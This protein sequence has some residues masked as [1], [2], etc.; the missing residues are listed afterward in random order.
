MKDFLNRT[1]R[2]AVWLV[3]SGLVWTA[4]GAAPAMALTFFPVP[5]AVS[6]PEIANPY[7]GS[8]EWNNETIQPSGWPVTDAY[9]RL[10]WNQVESDWNPGTY[11]FGA[12]DAEL[13]QVHRD[14]GGRVG[15]RIMAAN[16]SDG[17]S[18]VPEYL[19]QQMPLGFWFTHPSEGTDV[20]APDW[21]DPDFLDRARAL[22]QAL[23]ARY[24]ADP[25]F[26]WLDIGFYGDWGEWH[27]SQWPYPSP[28][29]AVPMTSQNKHL[30]ID[31][32]LQ[33]FPGKPLVMIIDDADG[34]AYALGQ[35]GRVGLR[36]D[37][38][39]EYGFQRDMDRRFS[40]Y[41]PAAER[42]KTAPIITEF[43]NPPDMQVAYDQV[44]A[45]HVS[46]VGNGNFWELSHYS[47][48]DQ[49]F[50]KNLNKLAGYRYVL[51]SLSLP[52]VILTG[53][54]FPATS[55]WLNVD[56]APSY[57]NWD[58]MLQLRRPGTGQVQWQGKSSLDFRTL[59][60]TANV[61]TG[62]QNP[63][64]V[65]DHFTVGEIPAGRYDVVLVVE[66]PAGY[67]AP[68]ALAIQGRGAD[69]GYFLGQV[70]VE[71]RPAPPRGLRR[72]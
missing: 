53:V 18:S 70:S 56:V 38:L 64:A 35:S 57:Q 15:L 25:R 62:S 37:S 43:I 61:I 39:G 72:R 26:G 52:D 67:S 69:G 14:Y 54:E 11:N 13:T 49:E 66:D 10:R 71:T 4:P 28:S 17:G 19:M 2:T 46:M 1:N 3:F 27:L 48:A 63:V 32:H 65:N 50:F 29:G 22:L 31:Y 51:E 45:Y 59:L 36:G 58:V 44:F 12:I 9:L 47:Q 40:E 60:P 16:S 7:R 33:A 8:Y 42:W 24:N 23:G 68:L 30:L 5:I 20:Y 6:A 55:R 41:P 21:N 34:L